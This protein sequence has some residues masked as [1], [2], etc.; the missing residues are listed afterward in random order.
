MNINGMHAT[1]ADTAPRSFPDGTRGGEW[2]VACHDCDWYRTGAY[3]GG[4]TEPDALRLAHTIGTV[5]E[6]KSL[7]GKETRR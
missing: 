6:N 7:V 5:H 4:M 1:D 3:A 2:M